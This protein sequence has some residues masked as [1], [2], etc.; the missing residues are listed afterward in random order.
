MNLPLLPALLSGSYLVIL[1][2]VVILMVAT[3]GSP[4]L[5]LVLALCLANLVALIRPLPR[6]LMLTLAGLDA[7]AAVVMLVVSVR[8]L[9]A[10]SVAPDLAKFMPVLLYLLVFVPLIGALHLLRLARAA[11]ASP[12]AARELT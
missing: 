11:H 10:G 6:G 8:T 4:L 7:L 2:L 12:G 5:W 9:A 1:Y 3:P